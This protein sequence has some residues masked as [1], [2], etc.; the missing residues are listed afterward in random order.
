[1]PTIGAEEL[2]DHDKKTDAWVAVDGVVYDVTGYVAK[3]LGGSSVLAHA[4][5]RDVSDEFR[6]IHGFDP[7]HL[8]SH[9][10][11]VAI[12]EDAAVDPTAPRPLGF[13]SPLTQ[14]GSPVASFTIFDPMTSS[15][16]YAVGRQ[17]PVSDQE[18]Q[19]HEAFRSWIQDRKQFG[20]AAGRTAIS[21]ATYG[22]GVYDK[23]LGA[24]GNAAQLAADLETW[25]PHQ[26]Q[27]WNR[28]NNYTTFVAVFPNS[29]ADQ[30]G[31]AFEDALFAE[32]QA[33]HEHDR[34]PWPNGYT[35]DATSMSFQYAFG[36]RRYFVVGLHPQASRTSRRFEY[37]AL[38]FNAHEQ[39][40]NL[41]TT[42]EFAEIKSS[43]RK[44][45]IRLDGEINPNLLKH[46]PGA[47]GA[48]EFSGEDHTGDASWLPP[49]NIS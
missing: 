34:Q 33:L 41:K 1:L 46:P 30:G 35:K 11:K 45:D 31:Q 16:H 47:P 37:S 38:V 4:A 29:N 39:F 3:H 44:N 24:P 25:I 26:T 48:V 15:V 49:L 22:L 21:R 19:V 40:G 28:G 23:P 14:G 12:L 32:L 9:Y 42:G 6:G 10:P 18:R 5:G 36:G 43:T 20:C 27:E 2:A 13:V 17:R 7:T 8:L